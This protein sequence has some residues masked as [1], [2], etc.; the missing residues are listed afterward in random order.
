M[1][2]S[3]GLFTESGNHSIFY[4]NSSS[5]YGDTSFSYGLNH[6]SSHSTYL[7]YKFLS[8]ILV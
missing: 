7:P 6:T 3:R 2:I 8:G 1:L 4:V 5:N